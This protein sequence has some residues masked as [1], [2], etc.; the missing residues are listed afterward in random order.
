MIIHNTFAAAENNVLYKSFHLPVKL[1]LKYRLVLA[2]F[3]LFMLCSSSN[4]APAGMYYFHPLHGI[5]SASRPLFSPAVRLCRFFAVPFALSWRHDLGVI[6]SSGLK[7]SETA[8][9]MDILWNNTYFPLI[10][11]GSSAAFL[12]GSSAAEQQ[13]R[14]IA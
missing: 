7:S 6:R 10:F 1:G 2:G 3:I 12:L 9:R 14:T 5:S 4:A 11:S 13:V 8:V